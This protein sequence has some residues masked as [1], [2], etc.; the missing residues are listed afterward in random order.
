M[1]REHSICAI[2][3][4]LFSGCAWADAAVAAK[5]YRQEF[6]NDKGEGLQEIGWDDS[7]IGGNG[8]TAG[9]SKNDAGVQYLWWYNATGLN[10]ATTVTAACVTNKMPPL[11]VSTPD[12]TFSWEQRLENEKDDNDTDVA[13]TPAEL[14]LAVE[15]GGKWYASAAAFQTTPAGVGNGGKWDAQKIVFDPAAKNWRELTLAGSDAKLGAAPA[16]NLSGDL[17]GVGFVAVFAQH[18]TVNIHFLQIDAAAAPAMTEQ[19]TK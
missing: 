19:N 15:V 11:P 14:R 5:A 9:V 8:N 2:F 17:T 16:D 4:A 1:A 6:S 3:L 13:G 18:Q 10:P 7:H 12:V